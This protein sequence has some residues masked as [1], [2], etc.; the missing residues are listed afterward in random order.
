MF[1]NV[2]EATANFKDQAMAHVNDQ[3]LN[4]GNKVHQNYSQGILIEEGCSAEV[5]GNHL[6]KNIMANIA[7]GGSYSDKTSIQSNKI[8][9]SKEEGIFVVEG[10]A[11]L[12]IMNNDISENK[13]GIVLVRSDGLVQ[14]NQILGNEGCGI[15][16]V[17]DS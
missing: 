2:I 12:M 6:I 3:T 15:L 16:I 5:F 10:R 8:E 1:Y 9:K 4:L 14:T 7:L 13:D 11:E 17:D